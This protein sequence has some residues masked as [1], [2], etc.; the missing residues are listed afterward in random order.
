MCLNLDSGV[1]NP[2]TIDQS[3]IAANGMIA[4]DNA[5]IKL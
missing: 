4:N 1:F 5:A 3:F 2:E